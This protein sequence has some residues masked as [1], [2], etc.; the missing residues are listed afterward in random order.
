MAEM[1]RSATPTAPTTPPTEQEPGTAEDQESSASSGVMPVLV[2]SH[3]GYTLVEHIAEGGQ[4]EIW[5]AYDERLRRTVALKRL[6]HGVSR[7]R[8]D[9]EIEI[10][11]KLIHPAIATLYSSGRW[12]D[13]RPF[14]TMPLVSP[15][16]S[17]HGVVG[18]DLATRLPLMDVMLDVCQAVGYAHS[19]R[20]L[21]RDLKPSNVLVGEFGQALV[22]DW[23]MATDFESARVPQEHPVGT[24]SFASPEQAAGRSLD[25][26]SD[27]YS[28]GAMLYFIATGRAPFPSDV[29]WTTVAATPPRPP[30]SHEPGIDH[31]LVAIIEKA[32]RPVPDDR[33]ATAELL[34]DDLVRFLRGVPVAARRLSNVANLAWTLNQQRTYLSLSVWS[35]FIVAFLVIHAGLHRIAHD[36]V[37][38]RTR[39]HLASLAAYASGQIPKQA[40]ASLPGFDPMRPDS[41][42][43]NQLSTEMMA[44]CAE[45]AARPELR[46]L[47]KHLRRI[48]DLEDQ[49]DTE[50]RRLVKYAWIM[51]RGRDAQTAEYVYQY[52]ADA[53]MRG[54]LND[55]ELYDG[56]ERP[57]CPGEVFEPGAFPKLEVAFSLKD[58][59]G[60][61][62]AN[63]DHPDPWGVTMSGYA[64]LRDAKGHLVGV[65]GLD[66]VDNHVKELDAKRRHGMILIG[67][68]WFLVAAFMFMR[69]LIEASRRREL[70]EE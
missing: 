36:Q 25:E 52:L 35:G 45:R 34:R 29:A 9:N 18:P 50:G 61:S 4:G 49:T 22:I 44:T 39:A 57:S 56:D 15:S 47:A 54:P 37:V 64:A 12:V 32:M 48:T 43:E 51:T 17:L 55:P 60:S 20:I 7:E 26:R 23:G 2:L 5:R 28:L 67:V 14:Y 33:Y 69:A 65:L 21:H 53:D 68:T 42:R 66:A 40:L 13:G 1:L 8:F 6:R 24:P 38:E 3:G 58:G 10:T 63:F 31:D 19:R 46:A 16:K 11:A 70:R 27:I 62:D 30:T 41:G 59:K